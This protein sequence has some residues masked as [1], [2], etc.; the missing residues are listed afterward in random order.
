MNDVERISSCTQLIEWF[1]SSKFVSDSLLVF[2]TYSFISA[3]IA[4]Y[5]SGK[6]YLLCFLNSSVP[7]YRHYF[8]FQQAKST[9]KNHTKSFLIKQNHEPNNQ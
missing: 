2:H 4:E 5:K 8:F 3:N 9:S 7:P 6:I 1:F